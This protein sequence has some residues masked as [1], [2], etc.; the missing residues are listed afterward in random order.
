[1]EKGEIMGRGSELFWFLNMKKIP[2]AQQ[3]KSIFGY[4]HI[5]DELKELRMEYQRNLNEM[6]KCNAKTSCNPSE[7]IQK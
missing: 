7:K 3:C 1:M 6:R 5:T 2:T 4:L